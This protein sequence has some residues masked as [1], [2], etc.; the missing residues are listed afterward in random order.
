MAINL[1]VDGTTTIPGGIKADAVVY[2]PTP[3][4]SGKFKATIVRAN[5]QLYAPTI[6]FPKKFS[7]TIVRADAVVYQP[8]TI[9]PPTTIVDSPVCLDVEGGAPGASVTGEHC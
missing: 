5:A 9:P 2:Q 8:T 1:Q 7:A 4:I 6:L 3:R